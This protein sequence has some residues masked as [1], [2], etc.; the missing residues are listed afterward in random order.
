MF[1]MVKSK[2]MNTNLS[3]FYFVLHTFLKK[4]TIFSWRLRKHLNSCSGSK[5]LREEYPSPQVT[6]REG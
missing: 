5:S 3:H 4:I 6:F 1:A 2:S